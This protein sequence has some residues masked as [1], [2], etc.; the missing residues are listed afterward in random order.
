M[1]KFTH[2]WLCSV[3]IALICGCATTTKSPLR[4]TAPARLDQRDKW[5]Y[6]T[7]ADDSHRYEMPWEMPPCPAVA[8]LEADRIYTFTIVNERFMGAALPRVVRVEQDGL[9]I[10]DREICEVH[11]ATMQRKRVRIIYGLVRPGPGSPSVDTER[12]RFP[13][14]REVAFGGCASGP[15]SPKTR[16]VFVCSECKAAYLDWRKQSSSTK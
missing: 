9:M 7:I 3:V 8:P 16:K 2:F 11:H 5:T 14:S 4:V 15:R 13:H 10:Y 1:T 12:S 6:L